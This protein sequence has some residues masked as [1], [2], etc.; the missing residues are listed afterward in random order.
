MIP[1]PDAAE[2][3]PSPEN[4]AALDDVVKTCGSRIRS[5]KSFFETAESERLSPLLYHVFDRLGW[6]DT[7]SKEEQH[8]FRKAYYLSAGQNVELLGALS[9][10]AL[11]LREQD[12]PCVAFKGAALVKRIYPNVAVRPMGDVDVYVPPASAE[13]AEAVL[14]TLGYRPF[15]PD[16][17]PGLSRRIRHARLYVGGTRETTSIDLHWSLVGHSNDARSP[18]PHWLRRNIV[19]RNGDPWMHFSDTAHL[20]YLSAHM[21][22]QHYDEEIPL[23]WCLDFYLLATRGDIAWDQL[24]SDARRFGWTDAVSAV[25]F[26][27]RERLGVALPAPLERIASAPKAPLHRH[28]ARNEPERVLNE[29]RALGWSGRL[30]LVRAYVLPSPTYI[31][32]RYQT[33][34]CPLGYAKRWSTMLARAGTILL[35]ALRRKPG[36][37]PLLT[38]REN[39]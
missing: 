38:S 17:T 16:M 32:F 33:L 15:C 29:L 22:L 4:L 20:L 36:T 12:I 9:E 6:P 3:P 10:A 21:K 25:A 27:V 19:A 35:R 24:L 23:L 14:S 8:H 31:R 34:S 26:D 30:A 37:R 18:D 11:A 28:G 1:I 7:V 2:G 5:G 39:C 13:H